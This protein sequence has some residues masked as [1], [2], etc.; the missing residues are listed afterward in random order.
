[1]WLP[2]FSTIQLHSLLRSK[3]SLSWIIVFFRMPRSILRC[4]RRKEIKPFRTST[5]LLQ[6]LVICLH[7]SLSC[8]VLN[9]QRACIVSPNL[10]TYIF[11]WR[12]LTWVNLPT[13][14]HFAALKSSCVV[15]LL[16]MQ[17]FCFLNDQLLIKVGQ[18]LKSL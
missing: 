9:E 16:A 5:H 3:T 18:V 7:Q 2:S 1:M 12:K 14:R 11:Q 8:G 15:V 4:P 13:V 10:I 17:G 6:F